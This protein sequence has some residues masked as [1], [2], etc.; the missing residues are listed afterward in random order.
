MV[1]IPELRDKAIILTNHH[2]RIECYGSQR[3]ME[4]RSW[5]IMWFVAYF[6]RIIITT[7]D[8]HF[9]NRSWRPLYMSDPIKRQT[10]MNEPGHSK[11]FPSWRIG[12]F[13]MDFPIIRCNTN[14]YFSFSLTLALIFDVLTSV[15]KLLTSTLH[16]LLEASSALQI[17]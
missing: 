10:I 6:E 5:N 17:F 11:R 12:H 1:C 2:S 16:I 4:V 3:K 14:N 7:L 13:P 8:P 15:L 9:S